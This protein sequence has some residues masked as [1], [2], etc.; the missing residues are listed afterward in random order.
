MP[1]PAVVSWATPLLVTARTCPSKVLRLEVPL[2]AT[3]RTK[4]VPLTAAMRSGVTT[5]KGWPGTTLTST[6]PFWT[7]NCGPLSEGPPPEAWGAD[8]SVTGTPSFQ[9]RESMPTSPS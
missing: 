7:E 4:W 8:A 2:A 3:E 5:L 9:G 6:F 1:P